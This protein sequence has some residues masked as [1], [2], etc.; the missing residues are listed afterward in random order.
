M[1][2]IYAVL[3]FGAFLIATPASAQMLGGQ[4]MQ[5]ASATNPQVTQPTEGER[6]VAEEQAAG[7]VVWD[8]LQNKEVQ[9]K[10][11]TDEDFDVLADFFMGNMMGAN[12]EAMNTMM[13]QRLGEEGEEQMHIAMGKR[14]SGCDTTAAFP[15]GSEYFMPMM[16][17]H[18][19]AGGGMGMMGGRDG[20]R[21]G[22]YEEKGD[23]GGHRGGSRELFGALLG[24]SA[25]AFFTTGTFYYL[26]KLVKHKEKKEFVDSTKKE[27]GDTMQ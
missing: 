11:L 25:F 10:D 8:K 5:Q 26:K 22:F 2:H 19:G 6:S 3:V 9:C 13:A 20:G 14:L 24:V 27:A 23:F 7:K 18:T 17:G 1:K 16:G 21:D 4:M 15:Q 12:H